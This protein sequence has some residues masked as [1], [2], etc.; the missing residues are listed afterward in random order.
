M[1]RP[2]WADVATEPG[3]QSAIAAAVEKFG[4]LDV[5]VNNAGTNLRKPPQDYTLDE[6]RALI[7]ANLTSAFLCA[8]V[9][10]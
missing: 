3:A 5:L 7:D 2:G 4:R 1:R 6:W 9:A 10:Q 8:K